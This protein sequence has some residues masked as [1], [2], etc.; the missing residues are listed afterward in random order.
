MTS[1]E[2]TRS[3][4]LSALAAELRK[5]VPFVRTLGLEYLEIGP[6]RAVLRLPDDAAHHNHVG[7]PH[8]GA[9]FTLAESAAGAVVLAALFDQLSRGTPLVVRA[10][11]GYQKARQGPVR[12]RRHPGPTRGGHRGRP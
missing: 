8:A 2:P 1:A 12:R 5:A 4:E 7:G 11:I 3:P 9:L 6:D 10:E